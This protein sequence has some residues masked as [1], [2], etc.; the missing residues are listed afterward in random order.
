MKIL[1]TIILLFS[2]TLI[3]AGQQIDSAAMANSEKLI[4]Q[5]DSI[6]NAD[7]LKKIEL[8]REIEQLKGSANIKE[9]DEL[10]Q[11][12]KKV[13]QEDSLRKQ[14]KLQQLTDL[15]IAGTGF[16]VAPFGDTLF[17]IHTRIGSFIAKDRATAIASKI[18]LL[19]KDSNF[20]P[21]SIYL[22]V[23]GVSSEIIYHDV[24]VMS[25]NEL[26]A[27]WHNRTPED[28]AKEYREIIITAVQDERKANSV[29]NIVLRI[30]AI[31]AILIGIYFVILLINKLFVRINNWVTDLKDSALKGIKFRGYQFL[32]SDRELKVILFLINI[33]R[34]FVIVLALY[35]ALPLLFSVF[36][37][38]RGIAETLIGW[39][40]SP[41]KRVFGGFI[42]YL[43]NLFTILVIAGVTHYVIKFLEFV[44]G[45]IERGALTLPGFYPDWSKPTLN[46]V[47]FIIIAFSFIMIFPYLP[48]SDSPIFQGV[49][50]FV[51]I[52]L[53]FGSSSAISNAVAG[54]VITYMRPF[55]IGDRI[56]VGELTGDVIEKSILVTR[57]R[58]IKNED[59]TI[60]NSTILAGHTVNYTT[61]AKDLG[62]ILHTGVTI[63][64]DV[65]WKQVHELLISAALATD[66]ILKEEKR[67][68]FVLQTSLDDFYVAYQINAYTDQSHKM[69]K[70]YSDLHQNIQDKFNEGGVEI[71]SPH[72]R[73]ARDGNMVTIPSTYLPSDYKAPTFNIK[74]DNP[75]KEQ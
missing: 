4:R 25:V 64:Y 57:I 42:G 6:Q 67:K 52:L 50:V 46:I 68:P 28:L 38:T 16:P 43:P 23:S 29:L 61:S 49:S 26:E 58:T 55:K 32:D 65:P 48:G 37:W 5:L 62:L 71:L 7:S 15:K 27:L 30:V 12:L 2:A 22:S 40:L 36:P 9:R 47:K 17:M 13:E 45:E 34:L 41:L 53:S 69:A 75:S 54:L 14:R 8:E 56:K 35:I 24:V 11:Q 44:A 1:V 33:F 72:Y 20:Q 10:M 73:A 74:I 60:P 70:I 18:Q 59:I 31:I 21:D 51:G 3:S 66:G 63:G 19:Y 39:I